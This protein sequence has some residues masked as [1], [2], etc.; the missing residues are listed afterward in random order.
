MTGFGRRLVRISACL[1]SLGSSC[2]PGSTYERVQQASALQP[3]LQS[4]AMAVASRPRSRIPPR[5]A[6]LARAQRLG[7][8][9]E[10]IR[11]EALDEPVGVIIAVVPAQGQAL[12]GGLGGGL[13]QL[14]LELL[15][16]ELVRLALVDQDLAGQGAAGAQQLAS[17]VLDPGGAVRAEIAG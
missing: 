14:G 13:E 15:G 7:V 11:H 8:M 2:G 4:F 3:R 12:A 5:N 6:A 1:P 17:V 10:V 16:Q 9:G